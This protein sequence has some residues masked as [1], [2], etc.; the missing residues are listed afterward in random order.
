MSFETKALFGLKRW[1]LSWGASIHVEAPSWLADLIREEAVM[2]I[3]N[4]NRIQT[5]L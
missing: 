1:I 5:T 2:I 3:D 4:S